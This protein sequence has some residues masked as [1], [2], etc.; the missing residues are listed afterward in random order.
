MICWEDAEKTTKY[1]PLRWELDQRYPE[2]RVTQFNII[3]DVLE[4][5]SNQSSQA[6]SILRGALSFS[7]NGH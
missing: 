3:V 2:Y 4:G 6:Y 5:Y 7:N 1:G